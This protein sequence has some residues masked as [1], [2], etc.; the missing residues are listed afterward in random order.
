MCVM[1][2]ENC[3]FMQVIAVVVPYENMSIYYG[4]NAFSLNVQ[5]LLNN[6]LSAHEQTK[7]HLRHRMNYSQRTL[8]RILMNQTKYGWYLHSSDR[9]SNKQNRM[10]YTNQSLKS[11]NSNFSLI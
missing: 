6:S 2:H 4:C 5:L 10:W 7:K 3:T 1:L 11:L 9:F 8:F